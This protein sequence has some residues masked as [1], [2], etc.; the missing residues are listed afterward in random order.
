M[1]NWEYHNTYSG[2][3]QGSGISLIL[4]NI[5][6]NEL[7]YYMTKYAE[8]FNA[9]SRRKKTTEFRKAQYQ[10]EKRQKWLNENNSQISAEQKSTI[11]AELKEIQRYS[12]SIPYSDS[13]D[14]KYKRI[15]YIRYADDFLI[16]VIGGKDDAE[17]VKGHSIHNLALVRKIVFNLVK[18]DDSFGKVPTNRKL[19]NYQHDFSNIENLIFSLIPLHA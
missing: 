4:A 15:F 7:D 10:R 3:P 2:T 6:M 14:K 16:G 18:L 19:T 5:Y 17:Q 11:I 8:N 1:E 9:G 13:M 12:K